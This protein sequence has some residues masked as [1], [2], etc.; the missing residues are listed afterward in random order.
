MR[1]IRCLLGSHR[2][3]GTNEKVRDDALAQGS[4]VATVLSAGYY[5]YW[6]LR[7]GV[8]NDAARVASGGAQ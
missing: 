6:C 8:A 3:E 7:C 1:D 2:F 4:E 5:R